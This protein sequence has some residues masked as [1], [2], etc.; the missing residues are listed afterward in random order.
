MRQ[1]R[2]HHS[3]IGGTGT[4]IE[5]STFRP[6]T[7]FDCENGGNS[8]ANGTISSSR[9]KMP[10]KNGFSSQKGGGTIWGHTTSS[11]FPSFRRRRHKTQEPFV[12]VVDPP[13]SGM[14]LLDRVVYFQQPQFPQQTK[15]IENTQTSDALRS[16]QQQFLHR[17]PA[18][19]PRNNAT[20][21]TCK[22][23]AQE[24]PSPLH[25]QNSLL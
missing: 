18:H 9:L 24:L 5:N 20:D 19:P 4:S 11:F 14:D 3:H 13:L 12:V 6:N 2:S 17:P 8:L 1:S 15:N 21:E 16:Q 7:S 25:L 22:M 10:E 23:K